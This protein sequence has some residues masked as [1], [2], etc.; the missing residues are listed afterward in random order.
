MNYCFSIH[1]VSFHLIMTSEN[2]ETSCI[3]YRF[4]KKFLNAFKKRFFAI[5][6]NEIITIMMIIIIIIIIII[7]TIM[8]MIVH[9]YIAHTSTICQRH[10][11]KLS[12]LP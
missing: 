8:I 7:I 11:T 5:F 6:Y 9:I 2:V 1:T 12:L 10:I 4:L 3:F